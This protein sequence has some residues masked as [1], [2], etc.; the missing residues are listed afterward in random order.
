[1]ESLK[2]AKG[3]NIV[4]YCLLRAGDIESNQWPQI[5]YKLL[6]Q[7]FVKNKRKLKFVHINCQS[8]HKNRDTL[9]ELLLDLGE[10]TLY[11]VTETWLGRL[12]EAKIW[13][14]NANYKS[15][16]CERTSDIK[17]RGGGVMLASES[18]GAGVADGMKRRGPD[19]MIDGGIWPVY[20]T[21]LAR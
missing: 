15:F 18:V 10:N 6:T 5:I 9:N 2:K 19:G 14:L 1:M 20:A 11:E 21:G 7:L 17:E 8:L 12:D 16:R 13:E 3:R 4:R